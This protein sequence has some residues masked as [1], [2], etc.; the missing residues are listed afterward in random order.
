MQILTRTLDANDAVYFVLAFSSA[1]ASANRFARAP[2]CLALVR[3][4]RSL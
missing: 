1:S 4:S 2:T 3:S